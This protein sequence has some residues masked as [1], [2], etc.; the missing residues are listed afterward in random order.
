MA[1]P[2]ILSGRNL[3]IAS[4]QSQGDYQP[5]FGVGDGLPDSRPNGGDLVVGDVHYD[6]ESMVLYIWTGEEW[7]M[8][9]GP[10]LFNDIYDRLDS[11]HERLNTIEDALTNGVIDSGDATE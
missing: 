9:G 2:G 4:V 7:A 8:S 11:I 5:M 1:S 6:S 10:G 3:V